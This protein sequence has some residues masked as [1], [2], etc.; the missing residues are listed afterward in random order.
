MAHNHE[1]SCFFQGKMKLSG[2]WQG[3]GL[4]VDRSQGL[5][6]LI[7]VVYNHKPVVDKEEWWRNFYPSERSTGLVV[8]EMKKKKKSRTPS[9]PYDVWIVGGLEPPNFKRVVPEVGFSR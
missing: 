5:Q 2:C 3:R 7:N 4:A 8:M 6:A 1:V 9:S